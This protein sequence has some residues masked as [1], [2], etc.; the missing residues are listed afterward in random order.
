MDGCA[1]RETQMNEFR[2]APE[3]CGLEDLGFTI[4]G[5]EEGR[6][7]IMLEKGWIIS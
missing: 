6:K 5:K 3:D 4:H 2:E 7:L 1:R